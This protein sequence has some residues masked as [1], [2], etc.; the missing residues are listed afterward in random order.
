[1]RNEQTEKLHHQ[2]ISRS[3]PEEEEEE[4][5]EEV[6]EQ[7]KEEEEEVVEEVTIGFDYSVL[8]C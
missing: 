4:V 2:W 6:V 5:E 1:M 3:H 7:V 8:W